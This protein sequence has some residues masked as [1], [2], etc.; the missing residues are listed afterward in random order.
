MEPPKMRMRNEL[1]QADVVQL[2][3]PEPS[4][5]PTTAA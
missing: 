1:D 5:T 2:V 3:E 4:R